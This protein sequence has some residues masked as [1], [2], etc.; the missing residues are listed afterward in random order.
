MLA[1]QGS[2]RLQENEKNGWT[3]DVAIKLEKKLLGQI[4]AP[5]HSS[6][7]H[8]KHRILKGEVSLYHWLPVWL[9]WI[10]LFCK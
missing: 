9:V 4:K 7:V 5:M 6:E 3:H 8:L 2:I 10:C 1:S